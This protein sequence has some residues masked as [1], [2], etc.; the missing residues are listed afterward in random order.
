[1]SEPNGVNMN[2]RYERR[3][4][5][6]RTLAWII[7]GSVILSVL[8]YFA[9]RGYFGSMESQQIRTQAAAHPLATTETQVPPAPRLQ[10]DVSQDLQQFRAEENAKLHSYAWT[11][12]KNNRVRIPI[13]RAMELFAQREQQP[14]E[15]P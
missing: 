11:D 1:M 5:H 9:L 14:K 10:V 4:V 6:A 15:K 2:V 12:R 13:E 8:G 3:D 7:A